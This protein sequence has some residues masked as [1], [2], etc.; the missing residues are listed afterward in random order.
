M[1]RKQYKKK[2]RTIWYRI[3]A[4]ALE[5]QGMFSVVES[6][7]GSKYI[8]EEIAHYLLDSCGETEKC[9]SF[10]YYC[11]KIKGGFDHAVSYLESEGV[12]VYKHR[13]GKHV[14][15]VTI[16]GVLP[17]AKQDDYDRMEKRVSQT[18]KAAQSHVQVAFPQ[19]GNRF[20]KAAQKLLSDGRST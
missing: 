7:Y 12:P 20:T 9:K 17:T 11:R 19:M 16:N 1:S 4:T 10:N 5:S 15:Y 2:K 6:K 8:Y 18:V 14:L 3:I 13:P